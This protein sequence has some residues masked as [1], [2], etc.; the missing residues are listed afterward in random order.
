MIA[1]YLLNYNLAYLLGVTV[2]IG[3]LVISIETVG[4]NIGVDVGTNVGVGDT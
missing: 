1:K 2:V 3:K 4:V